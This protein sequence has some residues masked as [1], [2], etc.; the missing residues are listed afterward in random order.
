[1]SVEVSILGLVRL[2]WRWAGQHEGIPPRNEIGTK[3][4]VIADNCVDIGRDVFCREDG[5]WISTKS[6]L[7]AYVM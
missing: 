5:S 7:C 3:N 2:G 4:G 1:M 6:G